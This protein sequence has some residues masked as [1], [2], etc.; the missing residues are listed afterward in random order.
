MSVLR[1]GGSPTEM[2][3]GRSRDLGPCRDP[4]IYPS[5]LRQ[6]RF[7]HGSEPRVSCPDLLRDFFSVDDGEGGRRR[8]G[9][10]DGVIKGNLKG[11][12]Q[13]Q[14][15]KTGTEPERRIKG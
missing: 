7:Q 8:R 14:K 1:L 6:R 5:V 10:E 3:I 12:I 13:R 11:E 9:E 15:K 4:L 2:I